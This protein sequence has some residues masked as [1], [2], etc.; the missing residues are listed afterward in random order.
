MDQLKKVT[1]QIAPIVTEFGSARQVTFH[2][3]TEYLPSMKFL[4][5]LQSL[6]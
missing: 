2:W 1:V 5:E 3:L 6:D 4:L